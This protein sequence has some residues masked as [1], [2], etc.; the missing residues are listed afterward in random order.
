MI[1]S[2]IAKLS[3]SVILTSG[4]LSPM[5]SFSSEL[6][7]E[8]SYKLEASHV[9]KREQCWVAT[10]PRSESGYNIVGTYAN[11]STYAYQDALGDCIAKFSAIIPEG[12]ERVINRCRNATILSQL[13]LD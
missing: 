2:H 9:I 12:K 8:F 11:I 5:Q 3:K 6:S 10:V 1:F 4:T 13:F 7:C